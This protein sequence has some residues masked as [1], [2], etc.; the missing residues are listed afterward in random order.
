VNNESVLEQTRAGVRYITLNRP[1]KLNAFDRPMLLHLIVAVQRAGFDPDIRVIVIKSTGSAFCAGGDLNYVNELRQKSD[2][3]D[4]AEFGNRTEELMTEICLAPKPVIAA[5]QGL[6]Y[7]G[8]LIIVLMADMTI[9]STAASFCA[10]QAKRGLLDPY[11]VGRLTDRV[12][13][14]RAKRLVLTSEVVNASAAQDIGLISRVVPPDLLEVTVSHVAD[15]LAEMPP[16]VLTVF[17]QMFAE[18]SPSYQ[19]PTYRAHMAT[20]EAREGV[21]AFIRR[22]R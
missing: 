17:K 12:G 11:V 9:A 5:V 6:A 7:A 20:S 8:G 14:E 16:G 1:E 21:A 15:E 18:L 10:I 3:T 2:Q 19:M 22:T 4:L 13:V